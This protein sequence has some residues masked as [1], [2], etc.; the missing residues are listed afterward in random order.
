MFSEV[1]YLPRG[2]F[3][4]VHYPKVILSSIDVG[5]QAVI[6]GD[7]LTLLAPLGI[8]WSSDPHWCEA[9]E[10][11]DLAV[12]ITELKLKFPVL[13]ARHMTCFIRMVFEKDLLNPN[14]LSLALRS[15]IAG[16][17]ERS[18]VPRDLD[19]DRFRPYDEYVPPRESSSANRG[20]RVQHFWRPIPDP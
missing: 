2:G 20:R 9:L 3:L 17:L 19:K 12:A 8:K 13:E 7:F 14:K 16:D 11:V 4:P 18:T 15:M 5:K 10:T 1:G 6:M